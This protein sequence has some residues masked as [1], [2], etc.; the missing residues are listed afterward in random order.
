MVVMPLRWYLK[1]GD[2]WNAFEMVAE[3]GRWL[4]CFLDD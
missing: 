2:G 1:V 3:G 4:E